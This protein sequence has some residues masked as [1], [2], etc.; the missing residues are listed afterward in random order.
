MTR[1]PFISMTRNNRMPTQKTEHDEL[2]NATKSADRAID[3]VIKLLLSKDPSVTRDTTRTLRQFGLA[4]CGRLQKAY[5]ETRDLQL[6]QQITY[7]LARIERDGGP[8]L[9][10]LVTEFLGRSRSLFVTAAAVRAFRTATCCEAAPPQG[11]T[12]QGPVSP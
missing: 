12:A 2:N 9:A 6:R 7:L 5:L 11:T 10:P 8:P 4:A 1:P 3:R